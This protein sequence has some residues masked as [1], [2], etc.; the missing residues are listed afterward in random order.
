[1]MREATM[2]RE[3]LA[4]RGAWR[5]RT[6]AAATSARDRLLRAVI[7]RSAAVGVRSLSVGDICDA[8]GIGRR[9][10]YRYFG[11]VNELFVAAYEQIDDDLRWAVWERWRAS[12]QR[13]SAVVEAIV[14]FVCA[15]Q[16][17]ADAL[18]VQGPG[19]G[20][21]VAQQHARTLAWFGTLLAADDPELTVADRLPQS[22]FRHEVACGGVWHVVRNRVV[23]EDFAGLGAAVP[24]LVA[25]VDAFGVTDDA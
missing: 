2:L 4:P 14:A 11:D 25:F 22:A 16:R 21:V 20:D 12:D 5:P 23:A 17:R 24:D 7:D 6:G 15:D 13:P 10:F 18:L 3:P 19:A 8:A 9:T 1:M